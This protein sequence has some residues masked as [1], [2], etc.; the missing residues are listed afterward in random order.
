M[1]T[2][3]RLR[4]EGRQQGKEE[5][6]K[7]GKIETLSKTAIKLLTKKFG[8]LPLEVKDKIQKLDSDTLEIVIDDIFVYEGLDD[9]NKFLK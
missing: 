1:T 2:A 5:G 9:L 4:R 6:L 7:E 3:E 8:S